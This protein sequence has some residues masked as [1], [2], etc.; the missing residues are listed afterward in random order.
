MNQQM[1]H[2]FVLFFTFLWNVYCVL[3]CIVKIV[4]VASYLK[5]ARVAIQLSKGMFQT[6]KSHQI[7]WLDYNCLH[8]PFTALFTELLRRSRKMVRPSSSRRKDGQSWWRR[9]SCPL[10]T[11]H[12]SAC[13]GVTSLPSSLALA[14]ASLLVSDVTWEWPLSAWST[15]TPSSE[16]TRRL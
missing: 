13:R 10:W 14:S 12:A 4:P 1:L 15:A 2:C 9:K 16:T 7:T 5:R 11:V 6:R 8:F 3:V